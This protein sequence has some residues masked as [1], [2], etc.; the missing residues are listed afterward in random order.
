MAPDTLLRLITV[1]LM[2]IV[3]FAAEVASH[4]FG[5]LSYFGTGL[6]FALIATAV[7]VAWRIRGPYTM[8]DR[9]PR[10]IAFVFVGSAI[11]P[12]ALE[13]L[14]R[15][16]TGEGLPLELQLVNGLRNLGLALAAFSAWPLCRRLAGITGLFL[17]L[18]VSAM[19][20]QPQIPYYMIAMALVGGLWLVLVQQTRSPQ[21]V[22]AT[23]TISHHARLPLRAPLK[24]G[25]VFG[26]LLLLALGV[27]I[28][29][30]KR[31]RLSLGELLPTSGGTGQTDPFARYGIGDGPEEVA[32]DDAQSAGMV[33][34]NKM[35]EDTKDALID[36][37]SDMFGEAKKKD[38]DKDQERTVAGGVAQIIQNHDTLVMNKKPNREFDTARSSPNANGRKPTT[39]RDARGVFEVEGRTPLHIR[40]VAYGRYDGDSH[41]WLPS[42]KPNQHMLEAHEDGNDWMQRRTM[43]KVPDWYAETDRHKFKIAALKDN[44][45]PTPSLLTRFRIQ[46]V[47]KPEYF[48]WD[49]E[50][51]L[52]LAGRKTTPAGVVVQTECRTVDREFLPESAFTEL[53]GDSYSLY[54]AVSES[55]KTKVAA[56]AR[57]WTTDQPRGCQQIQAICQRLR[58]DYTVDRHA[59]APDD[60]VPVVWF[61]TESKRGPDYLFATAAA[62]MLRT[63]GY[64]TRFCL[65]YYAF[66]A[67]YDEETDHTPVKATDLHLWPE[68]MLSDGQWLVIEPTPGYDVLAAKLSWTQRAAVWYGQAIAWMQ[69]NALILA[70][71]AMMLVIILAKRRSLIETCVYLRW[72]FTKSRQ[73]QQQ[74][75]ATWQLLER[76]AR[77]ARSAR[78]SNATLQSWVQS[79]P[80][81]PEMANLLE[82]VEWAAYGVAGESPSIDVSEVCNAA[83]REW[84]WRR[85]ETSRVSTA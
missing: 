2:A 35:I 33:E 72:R 76:R 71:G 18:F 30:P 5:F 24:E 79:L 36:V 16:F 44:L 46:R 51:V 42:D 20:D 26:T 64:P 61:L 80:P 53:R 75:I 12:M 29:G 48:E 60:V 78:P 21:S 38:K 59:V 67:A 73:A 84:P 10:W 4:P 27:A 8:S 17:T 58:N 81:S 37:V 66:P 3:Y 28:G 39:S 63:M 55:L 9:M 69:H 56:L 47:D 22:S 74:I 11:S 77:L 49:H 85:F 57:E 43:A 34:S 40:V 65:G 50:G 32:G 70:A 15:H 6:G 68:V 62:M 13:L 7:V 83:I 41:R 25:L 82:L 23:A 1:L 52:A 19:G 54:G 31:V 45:V 14:K